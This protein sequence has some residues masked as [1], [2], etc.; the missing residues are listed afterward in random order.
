M[1][2]PAKGPSSAPSSWRCVWNDIVNLSLFDTSRKFGH[3]LQR[4]GWLEIESDDSLRS[5][6]KPQSM[7]QIKKYCREC[8]FKFRESQLHMDNNVINHN[9]IIGKGIQRNPLNLP[10]LLWNYDRII[11]VII[12]SLQSNQRR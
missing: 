4:S 9:N 5:I 3:T 7:S 6:S 1:S 2:S 11:A 8:R 12:Y 10:F